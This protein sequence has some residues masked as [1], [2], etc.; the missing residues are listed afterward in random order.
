MYTT[1]K[2]H[3]KN[4]LLKVPLTTPSEAHRDAIRGG[5][6]LNYPTSYKKK[7]GKKIQK[8]KN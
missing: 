8:Y 5:L 7:A 1:N 4:G 2:E 6:M 3:S